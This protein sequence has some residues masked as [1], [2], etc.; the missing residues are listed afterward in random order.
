VVLA[1]LQE[2]L[3]KRKNIKPDDI[4]YCVKRFQEMRILRELS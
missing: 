2:Q 1:D 3:F 4:S